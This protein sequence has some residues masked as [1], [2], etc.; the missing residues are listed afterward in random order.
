MLH[1]IA[2]QRGDIKSFVWSNVKFKLEESGYM[3][4]G[5]YTMAGTGLKCRVETAL[6]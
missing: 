4:R 2:R 3:K 5:C 1:E 6:L